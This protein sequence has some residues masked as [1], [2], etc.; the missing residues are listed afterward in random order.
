MRRIPYILALLLL[1]IAPGCNP[2]SRYGPSAQ[3]VVT[4]PPIYS[5]PEGYVVVGDGAVPGAVVLPEGMLPPLM[6]RL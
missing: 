4:P 3:Q 6:A 2:F 5:P 1:A